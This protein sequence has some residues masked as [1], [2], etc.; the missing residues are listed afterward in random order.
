MSKRPRTSGGGHYGHYGD[1][2]NNAMAMGRDE[3]EDLR[4][5][6]RQD[7]GSG[8]GDEEEEEREE[9]DVIL[10]DEVL[11]IPGI[12]T[13]INPHQPQPHPHHSQSNRGYDSRPSTPSHSSSSELAQAPLRVRLPFRSAVLP[14]DGSDN[15]LAQTGRSPPLVQPIIYIIFPSHLVDAFLTRPFDILDTPLTN[16]T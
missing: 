2:E 12:D 8:E 16:P 13:R 7:K 3:G 9:E 15:P 5:D 14:S 11:G 1:D 6:S 4:H 10:M